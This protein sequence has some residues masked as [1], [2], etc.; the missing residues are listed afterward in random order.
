MKFAI[1]LAFT[2]PE[3]Y[4]EVARAA[5]EA[6]FEAVALSDHIVHPRKISVPYPYTEDGN[7]RW[8]PFTPWPDPMVAVGAMSSV[9]EQLRF[10]TSVF[11]LPMRN[12]FL[13]AKSVATAAAFSN[14]RVT[15]GI[16]V[17]W[18]KDEFVLVEQDFHSRGRRANE[19]IEVLR[20]LWSGG[21]VEHHGR[22]YDFDALEMSPVPKEPVPIWVGGFSKA[23]LRRAATLGDGWIS[24]LHDEAELAP[25]I[26]QVKAYRRDSPKADEPFDVLVSCMDAF[27]L[28]GYR[29]LEDHGATHVLTLPWLFYGG[30]EDSIENK[31]DGIFRFADDVLSKC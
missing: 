9:T 14:D 12:P 8:E 10:I 16:G 2:K 13:V 17:G 25:L 6:G 20:K 22:Y 29:R 26:Q 1:S 4:V 27:E 7:P 11:V 28:D 3:L 23:A 18:M 24:D 30:D 19:A 31:R 15:L 21:W 5:D